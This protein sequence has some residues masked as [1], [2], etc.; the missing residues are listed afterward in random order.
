VLRR[1]LQARRLAAIGTRQRFAAGVAAVMFLTAAAELGA[2]PKSDIVVLNNGDRLHC[3]IEQLASGKLRIETDGLGTVEIKWNRVDSLQSSYYYRIVTSSG[4]R[5]FGTPVMAGG[6]MQVRQLDLLM[7]ADQESVVEI[8]EIERRFWSK[9]NGS[10]SLGYSFTKASQV[11]QFT[12]AWDNVYLDEK[13]RYNIRANSNLT[14][15]KEAGK[16]SRRWIFANDYYRLLRKKWTGGATLS[17]ERN[18]ELDVGRR[19]LFGLSTGI[20]PLWTNRSD[21][22]ISAG[23]NGNAERAASSDETTESW[24]A[25]FSVEYRFFVYDSPE[26]NIYPSFDLFPSLTEKDR[27]RMEFELELR[28]E[29]F[30]DFFFDITYY[31]S[32]DTNAPGDAGRR[33]DYGITTGVSWSYN[34]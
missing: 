14:D 6:M 28:K 33:M 24:E 26:T 13:N 11:E 1:N 22:F 27:Y 10:L 31:R 17:Y 23:V 30:S 8:M 25:V 19:V 18:D 3:Q 16:V 12:A 15:N 21:L 32:V 4:S 20:N 2:R 7:S 34:R 29:L 5:Y 9:I